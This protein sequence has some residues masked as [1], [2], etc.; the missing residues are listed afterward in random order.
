MSSPQVEMITV[1]ALRPSPRFNPFEPSESEMSTYLLNVKV[2]GD[3]DTLRVVVFFLVIVSSSKNTVQSEP[4][5]P[6]NA[7][8]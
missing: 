8:T 6:N 2:F 1:P 5:G 4:K 3:L 7:N